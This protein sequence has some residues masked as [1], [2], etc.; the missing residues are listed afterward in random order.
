MART[1]VLVLTGDAAH[2]KKLQA[3]SLGARDFLPKPFD[4]AELSIRVRGNLEV[5]GL[6]RRITK[7]SEEMDLKVRQR[8]AELE[9]PTSRS[10]SA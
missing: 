10:S 3:L 1:P 6:L 2:E 7:H 8:T 5:R 9:K 4:P